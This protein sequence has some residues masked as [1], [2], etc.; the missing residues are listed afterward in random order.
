M[1]EYWLKQWVL[2]IA[3]GAQM[4]WYTLSY[5]SYFAN[6]CKSAQNVKAIV[7]YRFNLLSV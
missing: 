6:Y 5:L 7:S 2:E 4:F 3:E 1:S